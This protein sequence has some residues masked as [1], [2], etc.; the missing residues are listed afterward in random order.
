MSL[1]ERDYMDR[2]RVKIKIVEREQL[3]HDVAQ[4]LKR[5]KEYGD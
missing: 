2:D 3:K 4:I 1:I 5:V